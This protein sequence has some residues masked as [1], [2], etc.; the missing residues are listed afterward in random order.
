MYLYNWKVN[1]SA[2]QSK[3][4]LQ[5][6]PEKFS[7]Y[8]KFII[9]QLLSFVLLLYIEPISREVEFNRG[10]VHYVQHFTLCL[11]WVKQKKDVTMISGIALFDVLERLL[12]VALVFFGVLYVSE[13]FIAGVCFA[14][15]FYVVILFISAERDKE[16]LKQLERMVV[17]G[18]V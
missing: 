15:F 8:G 1:N 4:S 11:C 6:L 12:F 17:F 14:L 5:N 13:S 16:V 9:T 10:T 3:T 7:E 18:T 2:E